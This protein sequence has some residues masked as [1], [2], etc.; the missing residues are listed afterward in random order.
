MALCVVS[1]IKFIRCFK[2]RH[3]VDVGEATPV[4]RESRLSQG[5]EKTARCRG[6]KEGW[7]KCWWNGTHNRKLVLCLFRRKGG[8]SCLPIEMWGNLYHSRR[9][10]SRAYALSS[11]RSLGITAESFTSYVSVGMGEH[12][13]AGQRFFL[14]SAHVPITV[15]LC[16][17]RVFTCRGYFGTG[18]YVRSHRG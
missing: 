16:A 6:R 13:L 8:F 3:Y 11:K 18:T 7:N 4:S 15:G 10:H 1:K 12:T 2:R 14:L 17:R 9:L 5:G